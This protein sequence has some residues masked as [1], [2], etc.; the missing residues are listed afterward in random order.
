MHIVFLAVIGFLLWLLLRP[1]KAK[2]D[3]PG[4][5]PQPAPTALLGA[6]VFG[7]SGSPAL[8]VT[9][10]APLAR[11]PAPA[12]AP[13][14][15]M[16]APAPAPSWMAPP[17]VAPATAQPTPADWQ[18]VSTTTFSAPADNPFGSPAVN[19]QAV[20][21]GGAFTAP[22]GGLFDNPDLLGTG[23]A[24]PSDEPPPGDWTGYYLDVETE[25]RAWND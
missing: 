11:A 18:P 6:G 8:T 21:M 24:P 5:T 12:P 10:P 20:V 9:R 25:F 16:T 23:D 2:D 17:A 15:A 13:A 7:S 4:A 19:G 3:L 1:S 22:P 14:P